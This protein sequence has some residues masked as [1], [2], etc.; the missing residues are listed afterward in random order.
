M[1]DQTK[2]A[3]SVLAL[4][5]LHARIGRLEGA[6]RMAA[7]MLAGSPSSADIRQIGARLDE[8]A[9]WQEKADGRS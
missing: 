1:T 7:I 5:D 8:L 9:S 3:I 2:V 4:A 6:A